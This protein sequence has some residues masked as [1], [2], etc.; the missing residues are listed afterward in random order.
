MLRDRDRLVRRPGP[1]R[2]G[3]AAGA[4]PDLLAERR[5]RQVQQRGEPGEDRRAVVAG[6]LGQVHHVH[7]DDHLG[8][9]AYKRRAGVVGDHAPHRGHHDRPWSGSPRPAPCTARCRA[10][11]G[12]R[13]GRRARPAAPP[14]SHT[15]RKPAAGPRDHR[16]S[17]VGSRSRTVDISEPDSD[18][19]RVRHRS[20]VR[21]RRTQP[22]VGPFEY[23]FARGRRAG[24]SQPLP[25]V[26]RRAVAACAGRRRA[27]PCPAGRLAS[28][29]RRPGAGG[30]GPA[31][32]AWLS[33]PDG[34][35]SR[36]SGP[37]R[38]A[39]RAARRQPGR[40]RCRRGCGPSRAGPVPLCAGVTRRPVARI[41]AS[42]VRPRPP[43]RCPRAPCG[44]RRCA[45]FSLVAR[46]PARGTW[47]L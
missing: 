28:A 32:R 3:H 9:V 5:V 15:G 2:L 38:P 23:Q 29:A 30:P 1:A 14:R 40:A 21:E 24:R 25:G 7:R 35:S 27:S 41:S 43:A 46:P 37:R 19:R 42:A 11:A 8:L 6:V 33:R 34:K 22:V 39:A 47:A 10:P 20:L 17:P 45:K 26:A 44:R 36:P 31:D 4:E 16:R 13:A 12:T 18:R